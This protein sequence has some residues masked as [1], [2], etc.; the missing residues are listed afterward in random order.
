METTKSVTLT[1]AISELSEVKNVHQWNEVRKK[2]VKPFNADGSNDAD[3][4]TQEELAY[5]DGSGLIT[6]VLG[7]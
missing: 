2:F 7:R 1:K 4:L 5:I 3:Y 6:K